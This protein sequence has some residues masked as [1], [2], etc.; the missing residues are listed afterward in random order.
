[1]SDWIRTTIGEF[2]PFKYG[3]GLKESDR[4][5]GN[6]PVYGS[7][8][9][10]DYHN[11]AIV[12]SKGVII[13]RKGTVGAIHFSKKPFC[14]IDT[15]FF[16]EETPDK[17][18]RFIYYLLKSV[19]LE[20]M[21]SDSAVPGLNRAAAHSQVINIPS[22]LAEQR[23]IAGVLGAL[24]DKIELN[25]QTN[26]TLEAIAQAIFKEWFVNFNFPGATGEMVESELGMI[27]KGWKVG[28]F[29][30][31]LQVEIGGDW[32]KDNFFEGSIAA[33]SLRGTDIDQLKSSG[34]APNAPIRWVKE[35][36]L[37]KRK[38]T[39]SDI[40][41]A[42]S[43][44][45]PIGKSIYCA[46]FIQNLYQYPITFSNFCKKLRAITPAHAL[47][48]ERIMESIYINGKMKQFFTGT[49]IPNLDIQSLLAYKIVIP[50]SKILDEY[51]IKIGKVK[52]G[53]LFNQEYIYLTKIRDTLL[54]KLMN[55]EIEV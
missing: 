4:Q 25:R 53:F 44:L 14:P 1:M 33:V 34:F 39:K 54:P 45:G 47:F 31:L 38:I 8:G 46:K 50:N 5:S 6:I 49:S 55:G 27:P 43:G 28:R 51:Y 30:D 24:D 7:N 26:A 15:T 22:S 23:A 42:G 41:I 21:N 52:F 2:C 37:E 13:G 48:A 35:T 20:H 12:P 16:I 10:V 40:L 17:E 3:L 18:I 36:S 9:I 29:Q 11:K 32:G 19:G